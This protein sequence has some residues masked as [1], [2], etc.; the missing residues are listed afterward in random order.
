MILRGLTKKDGDGGESSFY[1][2]DPRPRGELPVLAG[3]SIL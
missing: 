1:E 3:L 2:A